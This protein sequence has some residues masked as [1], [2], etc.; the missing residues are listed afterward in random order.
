MLAAPGPESSTPPRLVERLLVKMLGLD[1]SEIDGK[2]QQL[3][4]A[5]AGRVLEGIDTLLG[6]LAV[7]LHGNPIC[8]A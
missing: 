3:S 8:T 2:V 5:I 1:W 6:H 4:H 7:D